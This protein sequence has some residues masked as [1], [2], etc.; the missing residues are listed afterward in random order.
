MLSNN[1]DEFELSYNIKGIKVIRKH[2]HLNTFLMNSTPSK[3]ILLFLFFFFFK[4]NFGYSQ[5]E[6][7]SQ[8]PLWNDNTYNST[9]SIYW[10]T[11]FG[12]KKGETYYQNL[13][14]VWQQFHHGVTDNFSLGVSV[15]VASLILA[16]IPPFFT[17]SPKYSEPLNDKLRIGV[18]AWSLL[19]TN[20][21]DF[22]GLGILYGLASYGTVDNNVTVGVGHGNYFGRRSGFPQINLGCNFRLGNRAGISSEVWIIEEDTNALFSF[23]SISFKYIGKDLSLDLGI[24]KNTVPNSG[25]EFL[26]PLAGIVIPL[27]KK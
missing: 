25:G 11:A 1:F 23:L 19:S 2:I 9:K 3:T 12:L 24:V 15:E 8:N 4:I 10:P 20:Y 22:I 18:G 6:K 17:L 21:D 13:Y 14:L 7:I 27:G 5:T 26:L 16:K